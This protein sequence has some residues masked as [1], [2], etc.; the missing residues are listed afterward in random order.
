MPCELD[1]AALRSVANATT[2]ARHARLVEAMTSIGA[3]TRSAASSVMVLNTIDRHYTHI[4][5]AWHAMVQRAPFATQ[6]FVVAMD[7]EAADA[8]RA[9][10]IAFFVPRSDDA[11]LGLCA[12][13]QSRAAGPRPGTYHRLLIQGKVADTR[14]LPPDLPSWKMHAVWAA[15]SLQRNVLF[16]ESDVLW[17]PG[18]GLARHLLTIAEDFAPQRHPMT[19]VWNFGFFFARGP[20]AADFFGCGVRMWERRLLAARH[21]GKPIDIGSDQVRARAG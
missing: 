18:D 16:S 10:G 1:A 5:A 11:V 17:M 8:T 3:A 4:I 7:A 9:A 14:I 12:S 19:P 6:P 2:A 15:L 13:G 20:R 21:A